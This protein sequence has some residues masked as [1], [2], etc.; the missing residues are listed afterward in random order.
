MRLG[1]KRVVHSST[2]LVNRFHEVQ[3]TLTPGKGSALRYD[4]QTPNQDSDVYGLTKIMSE[5][6]ADHFRERHQLSIISLRYGWLASL[7]MYRDLA[8]VYYT[9]QFCFHEQDGKVFCRHILG[10]V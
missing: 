9:L 5:L 3:A 4:D 7:P 8:M 6:A 10:S 1:V 2:S